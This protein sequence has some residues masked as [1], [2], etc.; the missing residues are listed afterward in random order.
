MKKRILA[1]LLVLTMA[2]SLFAGC[3]TNNQQAT[4]SE[5][6]PASTEVK[7]SEA[8]KEENKQKRFGATFMTLNNPFFVTLN[9]GLKQAIEANGDKLIT[10]DPQLDLNKQIAGIE[11]L[12]AQG[13]DGIFLNPVDWKG[14]KPALEAANK[15]GVPV[16][17]VDAPVFDDDLVVTTVASDNWEAGVLAAK[18]LTETLGIT[19]G[20]VVILEHPTA[21]SAI[22]RTDSF[23][24]TIKKYPGL[25]IVAQQSSDG[26]LEQAMPVMENIIQANP[27]ITVV[28]ALNDPTAMGAIAALEA[29]GKLDDVKAIYGVDGSEDGKKMVRE[30]KMT[31]TSAQY[32]S[33]IG[34][35]AVDAA[36]KYFNGE[37]VEHEIKVPVKLLTKENVDIDGN[38]GF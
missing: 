10:L 16:F 37:Q 26:Q 18:H 24:E 28:M 17:V 6:E 38:N 4:S 12:I 19:E 25:K 21:K 34:K 33:E 11:D 5:S 13:V 30:G 14:I 15:A 36:Y 32:P 23:I 8:P 22:E 27:E 29:A 20:N 9:E 1:I 2:F 3:G 35:I 7:T 31:A